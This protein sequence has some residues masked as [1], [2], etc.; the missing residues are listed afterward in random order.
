M[1]LGVPPFSGF[2]SKLLLYQAAARQSWLEL[3]LLIGAT[4]LAGVALLRLAQERFLGP[5]DQVPDA[6]PL[7]LGET[8]LDRPATR[9]LAPEPRSTALLA[10]L[11]VVASLAIGLYPQPVLTL[12]NDVARG[13]TF[14]QV[15]E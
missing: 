9:R 10:L 8:E 3:L 11:V 14:V 15:L 12:I 1:L 2:A 7:L 6:A 5:S 13:L 4:V